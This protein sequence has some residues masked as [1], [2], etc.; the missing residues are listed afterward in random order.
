[1][2]EAKF[3]SMGVF[4]M[5]ISAL[6]FSI[7]GLCIKFIPWH[8]MAII[9]GRSVISLLIFGTYLFLK[10]GR[11]VINKTVMIGA[12]CIFL[13]NALFIFSNKL[14]TAANAIVLQYSAPIFLILYLWLFY[15]T[16][17]NRFDVVACL[18]VFAGIFCFFMDGLST[19][20]LLGNLVA[21]CAGATYGGVYLI[22]ANEKG[23]PMSAIFWGMFL[24]ALVGLP[25]VFQETNFTATALLPLIALGV[26]QQGVGYL[27]FYKGIVAVKPLT[28][29]I[30]LG[31][32]P[33]L[34]PILVGIFYGETISGIVFVGAVIVIATIL[35]YN[36]AKERSQKELT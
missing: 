27:L 12:A 11:P 16:K 18:F 29:C 13:T 35:I 36:I 1:M 23:D 28:G 33:V 19:G 5:V 25:F 3:D 14:T 8:P 9:G 17:P 15:K 2:K 26:I 32:E 21:L 31:L 34:N 7:G 30:I 4:Y 24:S 6:C 22:N 10:K 20:G